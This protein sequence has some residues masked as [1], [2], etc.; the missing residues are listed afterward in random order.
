MTNAVESSTTEGRVGRLSMVRE[1][2]AQIFAAA[3]DVIATDGLPGLT[4]TKVADAAGMKRTLVGHYFSSRDSLVEEYLSYAV[5]RY[6]EAMIECASA[7]SVEEA[8]TALLADEAYPEPKHLTVWLDLVAAA[9]RDHGV[10][11]R[12]NWL[13]SELWL[14]RMRSLIECEHEHADGA[15]LNG[16]VFTVT[17]LI[18]A[19][20]AFR[21]QGTTD[22][23]IRR[24]QVLAACRTLL[25]SLD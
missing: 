15:Q 17:A 8:L 19:Y 13:W 10:R 21:A 5:A 12:L 11:Q 7:G 14:P 16:A 24:D 18:E 3:T 20:W 2:R 1:R 9:S 22:H 6:G 4:M 25:D 23:H